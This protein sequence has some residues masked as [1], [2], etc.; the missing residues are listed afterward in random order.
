MIPYISSLWQLW[1]T[2][3]AAFVFTAIDK[4]LF[5][6]DGWFPILR[7]C[8]RRKYLDWILKYQEA[9]GEWQAYFPPIHF[10][11]LALLLED[12]SLK[13][14][15][16]V[17]GLE[18][19]E[20]RVWQDEKGNR[21]QACSSQIWD[22]AMMAIAI[23]DS[24]APLNSA[25]L[26]KAVAWLKSRQAS[27]RV[28]DWLIG[29]TCHPVKQPLPWRNFLFPYFLSLISSYTEVTVGSIRFRSF[30]LDRQQN[31]PRRLKL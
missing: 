19:I 7:R 30:I 23:C 9:T 31:F 8:T 13:Y 26:L 12:Y 24:G 17:S 10:L 2:D 21:Y 3:R 4:T 1:N 11:I 15:R 29:R 27:G 28:G 25:F 16:I 18:A 6:V 22:T 20:R 14:F 5:A